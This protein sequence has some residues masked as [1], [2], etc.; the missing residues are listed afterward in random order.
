MQSLCLLIFTGTRDVWFRQLGAE[1]TDAV[2]SH[3]DDRAWGPDERTRKETNISV[4]TLAR[5]QARSRGWQLSSMGLFERR[6]GGRCWILRDSASPSNRPQALFYIL[7]LSNVSTPL[8]PVHESSPSR[9]WL[10]TVTVSQTSQSMQ[11]PISFFQNCELDRTI[12][13]SD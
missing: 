10:V 2:T 7:H 13:A 8:F 11:G 3:R 9:E 4:P 12:L 6:W 5:V 1:M